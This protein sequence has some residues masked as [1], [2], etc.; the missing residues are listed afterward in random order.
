MTDDEPLSNLRD[1]LLG[2][3]E[4]ESRPSL[5]SPGDEEESVPELEAPPVGDSDESRERAGPLRD[6]AS[7]VD[8]R[9]RDESFDGLFESVDVG[10]I[11]SEVL[12]EQVTEERPADGDVAAEQFLRTIKKRK[13][14]QG[15][16]YFSAPPV[17][18]CGH[19]GTKIRRAVDVDQFEVSNCP[20]VLEDERLEDV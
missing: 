11:D 14:C 5:E 2:D 10:E 1:D 19:E 8:E 17:V 16:E 9:D 13:Y 12:W 4:T 3:D 6:L 7:D 18:R 15:C 20:K